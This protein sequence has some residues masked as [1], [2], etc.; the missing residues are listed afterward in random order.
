[1]KF[2]SQ[3]VLFGVCAGLGPV[4][5]AQTAAQSYPQRPIRLVVPSAPG[6]PLD[7]VA[8]SVGPGLSDVLGQQVVI[9]NRAGAG[10]L[11]GTETVAKSPPDG[12]TLLL[13]VSGLLFI[14]PK[15]NPSATYTFSDFAPVSVAA[16]M[17][18]LLLVSPA[19]AAKSV[20][21]L[22]VLARTRPGELNYA[23]GGIGTGIHVAFELFNL[24]AGVK[25]THVPYKGATPAMT[26]IMGGEADMMFNGLPPALPF[27]KQGRLRALAVGDKK[28]TQFLPGVPTVGES[29]LAFEYT[30]WYAIVAP[31]G[32]PPPVIAR[33]HS[34]IV[35]T[36]AKADMKERFT[37][38]GIEAIGSTPAE[39]A[40]F[41]REENV[42][43][44]KVID[45]T[46]LRAKK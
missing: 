25:I 28:R 44:D 11:I 16:T 23:S 24:V 10:G 12:Y 31:R 33:L 35:Q 29:G 8:R 19:L 39:F 26:G 9:D 18:M 4:T 36:L 27:V 15:I 45:A 13:G 43:L 40:S 5:A 42:R 46:G 41:L 6:G 30:S 2:S 17:P 37:S 20:P 22:I 32:T 34:A 21:E 14:V 7:I 38:Q 3:C 1:M